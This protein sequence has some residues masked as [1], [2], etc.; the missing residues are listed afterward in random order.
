MPD[1]C[2]SR[3]SGRIHV[4]SQTAR[5]L[6]RIETIDVLGADANICRECAMLSGPSFSIPT[7]NSP[8]F[9]CGVSKSFLHTESAALLVFQ[10]PGASTMGAQKLHHRCCRHRLEMAL[11]PRRTVAAGFALVHMRSGN[12][13]GLVSVGVAGHSAIAAVGRD[14]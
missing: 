7:R 6:C 14:S 2:T 12:G 10:D 3:L 1:S 9:R 5:R 11:R 8:T 13:A 4:A